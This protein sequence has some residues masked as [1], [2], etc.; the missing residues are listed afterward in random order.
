MAGGVW[1]S[2]NGGLDWR[3]EN[4]GLGSTSMTSVKVKDGQIYAST[5][6]SGVYSGSVQS[7]GS[8]IWDSSKS[9]KPKA[10]VSNIQTKIDPT[11]SNRIYAAAYPGGL[12]RSD[13][14]GIHWNDKNFL[15]PSIKVDDPTR[16]GYYVFDLDPT[17]STNVWLGVYGKGVFV[18]HDHM[19]YDMPAN[20]NN[21][22]MSNKHVK[23][24]RIN[25]SNCSEI[26]V[27]TE[28]GVF[29][30]RNGG[31]NWSQI[32]EELQT[33]DIR[34]LK[35]QTIRYPPFWFDFEDGTTDGWALSSGWALAKD[36]NN[37]VLQGNGHYTA[38]TGNQL[39]SDYIFESKI[40]FTTNNKI[41]VNFRINEDHRYYTEFSTNNGLHLYKQFN[42]MSQYERSIANSASKYTINQWHDLKIEVVAANIKI[43][44]DNTLEIDY[45]DP[46]PLTHGA[47]AYES[48]IDNSP[49]YIDSINV[50]STKENTV[51]YVGTG[52]YGMYAL[53]QKVGKWDNLER[54]VGTGYWTA[55]ERRMYQFSS[56][57]FDPTTPG[58]VYLGHFPGGFFISRDNGHTWQD[59]SVGLGNDGIFSLTMNPKNNSVLWAGTYNGIAMSLNGGKTWRLSSNGMPPEQWPFTVAIDSNNPDI[60][61]AATKNGQNKGL[62]YRNK[63]QGVVMKSTDG[64]QNWFKIMNGLTD[65]N[66]YYCLLIYPLNHNVLFLSSSNGVFLSQDSGATWNPINNGLPTTNNQVRDNVA[67]NLVLTC[68]N[69]T[70]LLGI[71]NFGLWKAALSNIDSL[72][73]PPT[74]QQTPTPTASPTPSTS[75]SANTTPITPTSP[76]LAPSSTSPISSPTTTP[77]TATSTQPKS[78]TSPIQP[79]YS[80]TASPIPTTALSPS[81]TPPAVFS[82]TPS[83]SIP[84]FPTLAIL[85]LLTVALSLGLLL[86]T[87]KYSKWTSHT[88]K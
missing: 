66:E 58:T 36:G 3:Q 57:V 21:N 17:N 65:Q 83:P 34:S 74:P 9:N 47:I 30:T 62:S 87:K 56:L 31:C 84:E 32:N 75:P 77:T 82:P 8:I 60:M 52:G 28:E 76:S 51:V 80:P 69:K 42:Q 18:S 73:K 37:H 55:W 15:T 11:D 4:K 44:V 27:G 24:I 54:T 67:I 70:L 10:Y 85:P 72:L 2:N 48:M 41:H 6:G 25:P 20:G 86:L 59:S 13:D 78:T 38:Y 29:V 7:N 50:T 19:D 43:Y 79:S 71:M 33:L 46:S 45:T 26:Y 64:G 1:V 14:G 23:A 53:A 5:Q 68:D 63:F 22:L 16:Q 39:W 61:Y 81:S 49:V 12:L 35:I 88:R 40:K